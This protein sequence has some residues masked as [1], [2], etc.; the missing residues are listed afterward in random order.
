MDLN[1]ALP[2]QGDSLNNP[3]HAYGVPGLTRDYRSDSEGEENEGVVSLGEDVDHDERHAVLQE[4]SGHGVV[5]PSP[6]FGRNGVSPP[7]SG[8]LNPHATPFRPSNATS[9]PHFL[10]SHKPVIVNDYLSSTRTT[11]ALTSGSETFINLEDI[12]GSTSSNH[13]WIGDFD[14]F[15]TP[16]SSVA[17][18]PLQTPSGIFRPFVAP[19]LTVVGVPEGRPV[20]NNAPMTRSRLREQI[21]SLVRQPEQPIGPLALFIYQIEG[22]DITSCDLS[23]I[24]AKYLR[25]CRVQHTTRS[26][27]MYSGH[28]PALLIIL[29]C[30]TPRKATDTVSLPTLRWP[31]DQIPVEIFEMIAGHLSRDDVKSMRLVSRE[32]EC[33][34]SRALFLTSVVPFNTEIYDMLETHSSRKRGVT[35]KTKVAATREDA[36]SMAPEIL[37]WTNAKEDREGK[38]YKGHGLRVFEGFGPHILEFGMSFEVEED[39]L[40]RAPQKKALNTVTSFYGAYNWPDE[41]YS[42]FDNLAGLERAADE[43]PKMKQAFS[44]LTKVKRLAL[45]VDSGLGWLSGPDVSIHTRVF[46]RPTPVF[47]NSRSCPDRK[48]RAAE[49]F[50]KKLQ[51]SHRLAAGNDGKGLKEAVLNWRELK[52]PVSALRGIAETLWADLEKWEAMD[53]RP[54]SETLPGRVD[55]RNVARQGIL[56]T[57]TGQDADAAPLLADAITPN[58]LS[59]EQKEWLMETEWAQR[60]FLMSYMLAVIDNPAVFHRIDTLNLACLSSSHVPLLCRPDFWAALPNLRNVTVQIAPDWRTITKDDAGYIECPQVDPSKAVPSF[61]AM[62]QHHIATKQ[63]I[64]HLHI[65]WLGGGEHAKGVFARNRNLL[66]AP[67][68]R[69]EY[70]TTAD[71]PIS[72]MLHFPY[73]EVLT[74]SNGWATP[75]ALLAF[76]ER[77][78]ESQVKKFTLSSVSL[79]AHPKFAPVVQMQA[80]PQFNVFIQNPQGM[81]PPAQHQLMMGQNAAQGQNHVYTQGHNPHLSAVQNH[82]ALNAPPGWHPVNL[83]WTEGHREGSWPEIINRVSPGRTYDDFL[84]VVAKDSYYEPPVKEKAALTEVEFVS[85]GYVR[86]ATA[87]FDQS[88]LEPPTSLRPSEFFS[89]RIDAL[90]PV[91]LF[92]RDRYLGQ[93]VQHMPTREL[94]ALHWIWGM[95]EG[96]SNKDKAQEP[97]YDGCLPGGTG[98]FSGTIRGGASIS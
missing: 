3:S 62:L 53:F 39:A 63:S 34:V 42:R 75:T 43:T 74:I 4:D 56:Y 64:K 84:N 12:M 18:T 87:P 76:F 73:V 14:E 95:R 54:V 21:A 77:H 45:S 37:R 23:R 47:D 6:D 83:N 51:T 70:M 59:K 65:G 85:C 22:S 32:F 60:A 78:K 96:W 8:Q 94:R 40:L 90:F 98:R 9:R 1:F 49:E 82:N 97:E 28:S 81:A 92:S 11:T 66:P 67:F 19:T 7:N 50:W 16:T 2:V 89:K 41:Q 86:L 69:T 55:N 44:H 10:S 29:S 61:R 80:F 33:R 79:T 57:T 5:T 35:G 25:L 58:D 38:V 91:M 24:R 68:M 52:C 46:H 30:P 48:L 13:D 93:I 88:V 26:Y 72:D 31:K 27:S 15:Y 71:S 20:L 17:P 36:S